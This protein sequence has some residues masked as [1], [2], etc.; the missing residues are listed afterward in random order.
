MRDTQKLRRTAAGAGILLLVLLLVMLITRWSRPATLQTPVDPS[1]DINAA[2]TGLDAVALW[3]DGTDTPPLLLS[4]RV[5]AVDPDA[6]VVTA[7]LVS[8]EVVQVAVAV[9]PF[10]GRW[11]AQGRPQPASEPAGS[12]TIL[13]APMDNG[14]VPSG[15]ADHDSFSAAWRWLHAHLTGDTTLAGIIASPRFAPEPPSRIYASVEIDGATQPIDFAELDVR[16]FGLDYTTV[17]DTG[18]Q[19]SWRSWV[20][21]R[22]TAGEWVVEGSYAV[23][24]VPAPPA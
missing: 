11:T 1:I 9:D 15:A 3:D 8:G 6:R 16:V 18:R 22:S 2:A 4:L 7:R 10:T 21:V 20:A 12:G 19:R 17:D 24:P 23:R 13:A 14:G 5:N